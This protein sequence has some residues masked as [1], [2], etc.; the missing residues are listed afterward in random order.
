[1]L[2]ILRRLRPY[3]HTHR[4]AFIIAVIAMVG[5][6]LATQAI[7]LAIGYI[8]DYVY[9][10]IHE[11]GIMRVLFLVCGAVLVVG[12]LRGVLNHL[13]VRNYWRLAES[14]VRDLRNTV[15]EKLQ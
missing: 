12:L 2:R 14:V 8:T 9:P 7:P 10:S 6:D 13:M 15:Y 1:M 5:F 11:P 3:L 4:S